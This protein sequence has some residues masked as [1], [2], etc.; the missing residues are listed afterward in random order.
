[1]AFESYDPLIPGDTNS[2][3]D[4]YVRDRQM[5]KTDRVSVNSTGGQ[6][7]NDSGDPSISSDGRY[8]TFYSKATNLIPN[9]TNGSWDVFVHD[10]QSGKTKLVSA[11]SSGGQGNGWSSYPSISGKGRYVAFI[12]SATNLVTGDTNG[13]VDVFVHDRQTDKTERVSVNSNGGEANSDCGDLNSWRCVSISDDGRFIVFESKASNLVSG[14]TNNREDVF[15]HDRTTKKTVRLSVNDN[16]IQG[17][18][19]SDRPSIAPDGRYVVFQSKA[20]NLVS[21]DTNSTTDVFMTPNPFA[22]P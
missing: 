20:D 4:V 12:S 17:N 11:N 10:R 18:N 15:L 3:S 1:M 5:G 19:H 2:D 21:G 7:N 22:K 14:D 6:A 16:G 13:K 9:D 8:V